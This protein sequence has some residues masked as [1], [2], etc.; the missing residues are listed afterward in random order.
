M[1]SAMNP[2]RRR[3]HEWAMSFCLRVIAALASCVLILGCAH[4][5]PASRSKPTL[6]WMLGTWRTDGEDRY[7][8]ESWT[9][10]DDGRLR[11]TS[12]SF[13]NGQ[14]V[15]EETLVVEVRADGVFLVASPQGQATHAFRMGQATARS[16]MFEDP[17]HDYPQ[18]IR[19]T[20]KGPDRLVA[21]IGG[22]VS[23]TERTSTWR[24]RRVASP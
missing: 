12:E 13:R 3:V 23:G 4:R 24:Y 10:G 15:F 16:V 20:L 1:R 8:I 22:T 5:E 6:D 21:E 2:Q 18:R 9:R 11:A 19:Y 14:K 7:T 17:A